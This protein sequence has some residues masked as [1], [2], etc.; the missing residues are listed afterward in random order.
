MKASVN[1]WGFLSLLPKEKSI[2]RNEAEV[3]NKKKILKK[4]KLNTK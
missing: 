1:K 4:E 3:E 2:S